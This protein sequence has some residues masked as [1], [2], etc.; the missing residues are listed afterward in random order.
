M[1][2]L[3]TAGDV[4]ALWHGSDAPPADEII[5]AWIAHTERTIRGLYPALD[6][7]LAAGGDAASDAAWRIQ[8][9]TCQVVLRLIR[10]PD[11]VRQ[12]TQTDGEFSDS[13]TYASETLAQAVQL[14]STERQ[15]LA[16]VVST[17]R[18]FGIDMIPSQAAPD[19][20]AG[21]VVNSADPPTPW[22]GRAW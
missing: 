12:Y 4:L 7:A 11:G 5:T 17:A 19:P 15:I 18:A 10:N 22:G 1:D 14:T 2:I 21:V 13:L 3:T 16:G 6:R 8:T 20:L 9:V